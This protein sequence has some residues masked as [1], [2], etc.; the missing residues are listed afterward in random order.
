MIECFTEKE[1]QYIDYYNEIINDVKL[2]LKL[3]FKALVRNA[4]EKMLKNNRK[5]LIK[6]HSKFP[7][8]FSFILGHY[9]MFKKF[10]N[11]KQM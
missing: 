1:Q 7:R 8:V 3:K 11:F 5:T 9:F 6:S 4:F 2:K 10:H